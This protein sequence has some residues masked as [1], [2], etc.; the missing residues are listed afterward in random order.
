MLLN[1]FSGGLNTRVHPSLL[2]L[3]QAQ[4]YINVDNSKGIL[5]PVK[6]S[7]DLN[8]NISKYFTYYVFGDIFISN[9]VETS[10]IEYRDTLY[11]TTVGTVPKKL[12]L[13]IEYNLG[14][15]AS[16]TKINPGVGESGNL[17]GTYTYVYTYYNS[18]TGIESMPSPQSIDITVSN[19]SI[20]LQTIVASSDPQ[21]DS[22]RIYRI[23]GNLVEYTLVTEKTNDTTDYI[24]NLSDI[25]IAGNHILDTL[26]NSVVNPD[27][28]YFTVH[29]AMLFGAVEDKLYYSSIGQ[30]DYWPETNFID[31]NNPI[32]GIAKLQDKLVVFTEYETYLIMGNSPSTFTKIL[33][34]AE[35]GC[36]S[37]YTIQFVANSLIWLSKIGLCSTTG[38]IINII[39]LPF[40]GTIELSGIANAEVYNRAYYLVHS[41]GI[42]VFDFRYN[43]IVRQLD[44][45]SDWLVY[46]KNT[47]YSSSSGKLKSMF[48]GEP[49]EYKYKSPI[50][51]EGSASRL[52]TYKDFYINYSGE[53]TIKLF[54]DG[55][56]VNT[57]YLTG[58]KVLNLKAL[59]SA[60]GYGLEIEITGTADIIEIYYK[61]GDA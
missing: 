24:D 36:I 22:I 12:Y 7:I 5:T 2:K 48:S 28:K 51:T 42:L 60:N 41:T 52:K 10:Y 61:T 57:K 33:F 44:E 39:S 20:I 11:S 19:N 34:D 6:G 3:N 38:G 26:T 8:N 13:N 58:T 53:A 35:Q 59:N 21:V 9:P 23:G 16:A 54:I 50:I 14:I 18:V 29:K 55:K 45:T 27:I 15:T 31:F 47:L 43:T 17:T 56:L 25:D 4:S 49:L 1:D 32:T 30:F 40:L 37:H 46:A